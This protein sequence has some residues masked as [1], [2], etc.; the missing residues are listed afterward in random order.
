MRNLYFSDGFKSEQ[1]LYED[2]IIEAV[3]IY[4]QDLYY[5]PRDLVNIDSVF[6]EDPVSS[7]N[8]SYRVE[9]YVESND[10][11]DGEGDLFSK[12]GVEIRDSVTLIMAKRRWNETVRKYDNEIETDRPSEG[13]LIYT[14]FAKKLFQIMHVEH[15][16]PF[17]QLSNLPVYK[18]NCSLFEYND[19]DFDTGVGEIDVTEIKNAYQVPITVSLTGGN[20][21]EVGEI[22]T[23]VIT[24]D[25]A[26]SVYGT[27]QTITKNSDIAAD[28]GVSNIGVTGSTEA[29]DF[30]VSDTLG[31]T[32]S[33]SGNTCF[34]ISIDNVA[35]NTVF[36]NDGAA[37]NNAFEIEA[38]GFLDFTESNPFGDPSETY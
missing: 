11:F 21:F 27:I 29:K 28:I 10:G 26:V 32:G 5:M 30:I 13:D 17:Y 8:S 19:E 14:P 16:Q 24:T 20:H 23:Q 9:M 15:E 34:A 33:K 36:P 4:G 7:F 31:L 22:V 18:L 37:S 6:K 2:L 12:F 1:L 3:K 25:P 35:D 38:D